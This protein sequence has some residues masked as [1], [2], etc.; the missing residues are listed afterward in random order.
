MTRP[1]W[2]P[3]PRNDAHAQRVYYSHTHTH[4]I[5][6]YASIIRTHL[7]L[8][9]RAHTHTHAHMFSWSHFVFYELCGINRVPRRQKRVWL[10]CMLLRA[11]GASVWLIFPN[12]CCGNMWC[13]AMRVRTCRACSQPF[14]LQLDGRP[15]GGQ[16]LSSCLRSHLHT[17]RSIVFTRTNAVHTCL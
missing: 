5:K 2:P 14:R 1:P 10:A 8:Y 4:S 11:S 6:T 3:Y 9:A 12:E 13:V 17:K 16:W 15:S 7:F